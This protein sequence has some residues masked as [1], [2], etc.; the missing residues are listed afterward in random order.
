[1][2]KAKKEGPV[3]VRHIAS[4]ETWSVP[5]DVFS[6]GGAK[7]STWIEEQIATREREAAAQKRRKAEAE[8]AAQAAA[9]A[10]VIPEKTPAE[11]LDEITSLKDERKRLRRELEDANFM[12]ESREKRLTELTAV[13]DHRGLYPRAIEDL[14]NDLR[15]YESEQQRQRNRLVERNRG[16]MDRIRGGEDVP[17]EL[18]DAPLPPEA[19]G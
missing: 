9:A 11:L 18:F 17:M 15:Q 7:A 13:V 4:G 16:L 2:S 14:A 3:S 1:M 8:A 5:R 10:A 6:Q 19:E 12:A